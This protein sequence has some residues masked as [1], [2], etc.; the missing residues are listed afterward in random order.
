MS[1]D[2]YANGDKGSDLI[3]SDGRRKN[4]EERFHNAEKARA[5]WEPEFS[6][7]YQNDD[8]TKPH[9]CVKIGGK[10]TYLE[11]ADRTL[12]VDDVNVLSQEYAEFTA[13]KY[14][15]LLKPLI[16]VVMTKAISAYK[17]RKK[18]ESGVL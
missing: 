6:L 7:I 10:V 4:A 17:M 2:T 13:K 14:A 8:T 16:A 5:L 15:A 12:I 11:L 18:I 1:E 9:M 3:K